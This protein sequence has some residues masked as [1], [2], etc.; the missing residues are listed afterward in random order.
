VD[1]LESLLN[2]GWH[3]PLTSRTLVDERDLLDVI[4]QMRIAVPEEVKQ[5]R[6]I[7]QERDQMVAQAKAEA[8]RIITEA[9]EQAAFLL[10]DN[11]LLKQAEQRGKGIISEAQN[12][13]AEMRRGADDYSLDVMRR[14]E[15]ELESHLATVRRGVEAL[16]RSR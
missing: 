2:D 5:A 13:A 10:Q 16:Q 15:S 6:R 8:E 11:E 3:L 9:Q 1:R 7:T 12:Q 14:L 4:D